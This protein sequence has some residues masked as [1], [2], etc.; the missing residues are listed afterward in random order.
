MNADYVR[1]LDRCQCAVRKRLT[2]PS[3]VRPLPRRRNARRCGLCDDGVSPP[4]ALGDAGGAATAAAR[5]A[6]AV[7]AQS[8][9]CIACTNAARVLRSCAASAAA[10]SPPTA[11]SLRSSRATSAASSR[12]AAARCER[13]RRRTTAPCA[14]PA[15]ASQAD[16]KRAAA[17]ASPPLRASASASRL[18]RPL[19]KSRYVMSKKERVR[20]FKV[21]R[22]A[23][24]VQLTPWEYARTW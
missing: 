11:R 20:L 21:T 10:S 2:P 18:A 16:T 8:G 14:A 1:V 7:D 6:P 4:R 22:S 15:S 12:S 13:Q 5:V 23:H 24:F 9:I 19:P 17:A 3:D